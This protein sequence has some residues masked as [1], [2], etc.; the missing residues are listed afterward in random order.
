MPQRREGPPTNADG[1]EIFF[2][3]IWDQDGGTQVALLNR[4]DDLEVSIINDNELWEESSELRQT[5]RQ[6]LTKFS[7]F[8][9]TQRIAFEIDVPSRG[10][11][12]RRAGIPSESWS[13]VTKSCSEVFLR[14]SPLDQVEKDST[15]RYTAGADPV[16]HAHRQAKGKVGTTG[17][18]RSPKKEHR[19]PE[20]RNRGR[21][22]WPAEKPAAST[23]W[24]P[25]S[26]RG[27]RRGISPT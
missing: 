21:N 6:I 10:G 2:T 23:S 25:M 12:S 14:L 18:M 3:A 7:P 9:K 27:S 8:L 17:V 24:E 16:D 19:T 26:T 1:N 22:S 5:A 11:G 13:V 15:S 4:S 20:N